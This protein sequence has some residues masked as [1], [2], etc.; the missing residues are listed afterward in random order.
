MCVL[1]HSPVRGG[2]AK[3]VYLGYRKLMHRCERSPWAQWSVA[4]YL[5]VFASALDLCYL[6]ERMEHEYSPGGDTTCPQGRASR[7]N[8]HVKISRQ[9]SELARRRWFYKK[10]QKLTCYCARVRRLQKK[11]QNGDRQ[12]TYYWIVRALTVANFPIDRPALLEINRKIAT[13]GG[14]IIILAKKGPLF[15]GSLFGVC[16]F[17]GVRLSRQY[18]K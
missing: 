15:V 10:T 11:Q 6:I 14:G 2:F 12:C 4:P 16:L 8:C 13:M 5:S 7:G 3:N 9:D 17:L 1:T 18:K